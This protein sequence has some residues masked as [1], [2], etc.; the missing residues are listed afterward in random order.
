MILLKCGL[1]GLYLQTLSSTMFQGLYL[2][3]RH[4]AQTLV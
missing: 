4:Y 2:R 3:P 1:Q